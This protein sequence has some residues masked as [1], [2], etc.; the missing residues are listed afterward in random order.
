MEPKTGRVGFTRSHQDRLVVAPAPVT[1]PTPTSPTQR[2]EHHQ[3]THSI[4]PEILVAKVATLSTQAMASSILK[5][6]LAVLLGTG[7]LK[8]GKVS[9]Q[10]LVRLLSDLGGRGRVGQ[11]LKISIVGAPYSRGQVC[12]F[13]QGFDPGSISFSHLPRTL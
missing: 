3:L 4:D 6:P 11:P 8:K 7:F 2:P 12:H 1:T 13:C 10:Q 9:S 5:S